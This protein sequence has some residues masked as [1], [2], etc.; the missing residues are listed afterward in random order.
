MKCVTQFEK[1][2]FEFR[3]R[4]AC[5]CVYES[6]DSTHKK[7]TEKHRRRE[8]ARGRV[9]D[10]KQTQDLCA[11]VLQF[12]RLLLTFV[13]ASCTKN[14]CKNVSLPHINSNFKLTTSSSSSCLP[15]SFK[16]NSLRL[17]SGHGTCGVYAIHTLALTHA[18][19]H[20]RNA[21]N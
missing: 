17:A 15:L 6:Y 21:H 5:V 2:K 7:E 16:C 18:P 4:C 11:R 13:A 8:R 14:C 10:A 9:P 1:K 12:D 20:T 3:Y 19:T